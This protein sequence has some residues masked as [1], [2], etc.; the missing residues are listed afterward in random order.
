MSGAFAWSMS[1]IHRST[2]SSVWAK[3]M[4]RLVTFQPL[5]IMSIMCFYTA[6]T[7]SAG[8]PRQ[9]LS[10]L[11]AG[12]A[13]DEAP[14][15]GGALDAVF[16]E[17]ADDVPLSSLRRT[18]LHPD[19]ARSGAS[20]GS[21]SLTIGIPAFSST[22]VRVIGGGA[23]SNNGDEEEKAVMKSPY[24]RLMAKPDTGRPRFCRKCNAGK[25]DRSH[26]CSTCGVCVLKSRL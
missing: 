7:R 2:A 1:T 13:S 4:Y 23:R 21:S 17:T 10:P 16:D 9:P 25:P 22:G 24:R 6:S 14:L 11:P 20:R 19:S 3:L 8:H 5:A 18:L 12:Y 26:H 15:L